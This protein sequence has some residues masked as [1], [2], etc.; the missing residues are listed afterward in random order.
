MVKLK[1]NIPPKT[2]MERKA[3]N[4]ESGT[5]K[6]TNKAFV[7]PMKNIRIKVTRIKPIIIVLIKSCSV[8]RV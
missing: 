6:A 3:I 2:G 5:D 7:T 8:I 4:M 1:S